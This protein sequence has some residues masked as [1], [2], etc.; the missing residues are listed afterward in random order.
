MQRAKPAI[1]LQ[2]FDHLRRDVSYAARMLRKNPVFTLTAV[3]TLALGIG[4]TSAI[5]SAVN[6]LLFHPRGVSEPDRL[7][8][9]RMSIDKLNFR[10]VVI[11]PRDFAEVR[12]TKEIFASAA[13][14][15][16]EAFS[17]RGTGLP[18]RLF[19]TGVSWQWFDLLGQKPILGRTFSA[20]EDQPN[21][22]HV[23][24]LTNAAWQRLFGGDPAIVGKTIELN[25]LPYK[26]V[27]V[28]GPEHDMGIDWSGQPT[29]Q[30]LFVPL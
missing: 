6:A 2:F 17:F 29:K 4:A 21:A 25:Q 3:L 20:E 11:S 28:I 26:V 24:I 5:F 7:V 1:G 23:V 22:N 18:E 27:G 10:N 8:A 13:I 15:K 30:D 19:G 12:D 14:S 9:V 16:E